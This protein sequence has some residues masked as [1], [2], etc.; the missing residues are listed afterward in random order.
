LAET[1]KDHRDVNL[2]GFN[3]DIE[4]AKVG[5]EK[6]FYYYRVVNITTEY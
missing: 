4:L 3:D 1:G 2:G 5:R 6:H